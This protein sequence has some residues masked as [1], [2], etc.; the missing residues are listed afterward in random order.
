MIAN[1]EK[2]KAPTVEQMDDFLNELKKSK[3]ALEEWKDDLPVYYEPFLVPTS[4]SLTDEHSHDMAPY[5]YEER[6][7]Y[8]TSNSLP[9]HSHFLDFIGHTMN[10]Y[11]A[12]I[13]RID[14]YLLGHI[15]PLS[16][17][18]PTEIH[19]AKEIVMSF[20]SLSVGGGI[21]LLYPA[22]R[23]AKVLSTPEKR[24]VISTLQKIS[25]EVPVAGGLAA[26]IMEFE[27]GPPTEEMCSAPLGKIWGPYWD[28][29]GNF[30]DTRVGF[31]Q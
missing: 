14:R 10:M 3:K 15:F 27:M 17:P 12:A 11:K 26:H 18:S 9:I 2:L 16:N 21:F 19:L 5:P 4:N 24:Y 6:L 25:T 1:A 8:F 29:K 22:M 31:S 23:A 7:D 28:I 20:P 13:L 30:L